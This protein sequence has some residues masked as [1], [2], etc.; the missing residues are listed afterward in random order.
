MDKSFLVLFFKKGL[1]ACF[2]VSSLAACAKYSTLNLPSPTSMPSAQGID[3]SRA[4][5]VADVERLALARNPDLAASRLQRGVSQAQMLQAG[6]LANPF[7]TGA[8]L[9][10][11]AGPAAAGPQGSAT[12]AYNVGLSYDIRSLIAR[13]NRRLAAAATSRSVDASLLWQEWQ[14]VAQAR[15]LCVDIVLGDRIL[16]IL[17]Q[18][19]NLVEARVRASRIAL[20]RGDATL[21]TVAP[22]EAALLSATIAQ[23]DQDRLQLARRHQLAAL[24]SLAPDTPL[25]L[26][27]NPDIPAVSSQQADQALQDLPERRPDLAALRFGYQAQDAKLRSA[28]LAQFPNLTFGI[29]GGSD[30]SNIRNIG[31][32]VTLEIPIFD[33]GQGQIALETATRV[34]LRAEYTARLAA[35]IGQIRAAVTELRLLSGQRAALDRDAPASRLAARDAEAASRAGDLEER[36]ALDL[37]LAQ[38]GRAQQAVLL[39][40]MML[41]QSVALATLIGAGMPRMTVREGVLF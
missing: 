11:L 35:S 17:R 7:L 18:S 16:D 1:L 12:L 6:L 40:Q 28:I 26:A 23:A 24:L 19:R 34:Q 25:I 38:T 32:Q 21:A 10:L 29:T 4:L 39:E 9:P 22:D 37:I 14:T 20:A 36:S 27:P 41:E 5:R 3:L 33:R 13:P 2:A 31:P 30:N 15:L 8:V